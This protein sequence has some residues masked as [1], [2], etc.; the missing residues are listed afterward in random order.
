M[1]ILE[2]ERMAR[3]GAEDGHD[4]EWYAAMTKSPRAEATMKAAADK[5]R[6]KL[7]DDEEKFIPTTIR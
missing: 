4:D 1:S 6:Q 3:R 7:K 2:L 5:A